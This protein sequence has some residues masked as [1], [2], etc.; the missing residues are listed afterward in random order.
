M[1]IKMGDF[2]TSAI[3]FACGAGLFLCLS[4]SAFAQ[5]ATDTITCPANIFPYCS[6][7]GQEPDP[8]PSPPSP[9]HESCNE[10]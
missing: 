1:S 6:Q 7:N 10:E 8:A 2:N 9:S 4:G 3:A 5:S